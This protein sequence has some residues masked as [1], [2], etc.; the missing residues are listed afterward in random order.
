[1]PDNLKENLLV[2]FQSY[3]NEIDFDLLESE[4][5]ADFT[6]IFTELAALRTEVKTETRQFKQTLDTL[7]TAV[8][9]LREDNHTLSKELDSQKKQ[10]QHD[11]DDLSRSLLLDV[12]DIYD[13]LTHGIT[14][15]E[16]Y[17]PAPSLF[18]SFQKDDKRFMSSYKEGQTLLIKRFDNFLQRNN[19]YPIDCVGKEIDPQTMKAIEVAS[20]SKFAN[21]VVVEELRRGF[22]LGEKVL[23]FAEVKVNKV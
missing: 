13:R 5:E 7:T 9:A 22:M 20:D 12:L 2:Q 8:N 15:L 10:A 4:Q 23:R 18:R 21:G 6:A 19:V 3:L 1:M 17:K 14:I 16:A 11:R